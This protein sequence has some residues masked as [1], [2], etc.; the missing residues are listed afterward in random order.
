MDF[1]VYAM[2]ALLVQSKYSNVPFSRSLR[3]HR[4]LL[5]I[6]HSIAL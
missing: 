4:D 2:Q 6:L 5:L 1:P 3:S